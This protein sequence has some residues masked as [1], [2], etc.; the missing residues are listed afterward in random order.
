M[1]NQ[2]E[3]KQ[4]AKKGNNKRTVEEEVE[5][6]FGGGPR[7]WGGTTPRFSGVV[8]PGEESG[9]HPGTP[10]LVHHGTQDSEVIIVGGIVLGTEC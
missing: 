7:F 9:L 4:T 6:D 10:T 5:V 8:P 3:T 1:K 2:T